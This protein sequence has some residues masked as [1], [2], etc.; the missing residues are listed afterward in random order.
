[1]QS[2]SKRRLKN[3]LIELYK[4]IYNI[5]NLDFDSYLSFSS[6]STRGNSL[7]INKDRT[8]NTNI[9]KHWYFN[10]VVGAW[11]LLPEA[12]VSIQNI[13]SF[14]HKLE[15]HLDSSSISYFFVG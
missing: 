6:N 13:H 11:N 3:D 15:N 14:K 1:M 9:A 12:I 4:I 10:R 8:C 7:K 5:N 2:L